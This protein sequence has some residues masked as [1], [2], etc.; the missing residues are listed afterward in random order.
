MTRTGIATGLGCLMALSGQAIADIQIDVG[1]FS[2]IN[3]VPACS[4]EGDYAS[5]VNSW[6]VEGYTSSQGYTMI[7]VDITG[8]MALAGESHLVG[9]SIVDFGTNSYGTLS[10]GAD[11]DYVQFIGLDSDIGVEAEY[12]GGTQEHVNQDSDELWNRLGVLD[13]FYGANH[14]EDEVYVSLGQLGSLDLSFS[15]IGGGDSGGG[16]GTDDGADDDFGIDPM[17]N[18]AFSTGLHL[19]LAEVGSYEQFS[20]YLHTADIPAPAGVAVMLGMMR[21]GRR[22]RS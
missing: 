5:F 1:C 18:L 15:N 11:L 16:D 12:F 17:G 14:I 2:N 6:E 19:Q 21:V 13:A 8:I 3:P 4:Y 7:D 9:V 22:R 10:P 20:I